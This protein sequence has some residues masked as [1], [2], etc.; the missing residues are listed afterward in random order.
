MLKQKIRIQLSAN[1][2]LD[3]HFVMLSQRLVKKMKIP[4]DRNLT[5]SFGAARSQIRVTANSRLDDMEM[6]TK[7]AQS[8][9]LHHNMILKLTYKPSSKTL[10]LGPILGVMVNRVYTKSAQRPFGAL[11]PFCQELTEACNAEG[12]Y[13]YF[14][15]PP[16]SRPNNQFMEGWSYSKGWRKTEV[17]IPNVVYNRLTTRLHENK[18]SVQHFMMDVKS[19][20]GS[21]VFNEKFLNKTEVF[22]ALK[23]ESSLKSVLP[24]SHPLRSFQRLKSMCSRHSTVFVKPILGS[25]GKGIIRICREADSSYTCYFAQ[26]NGTQKQK[27][28]NLNRVYSSISRKIRARRYQIQQGL[29]LISIGSRL[30]DFRSLVQRNHKGEWSV[31]SIVARIASQQHFV[32]NLARGGTI[33]SVRDALIK[34]NLSNSIVTKT[35]QKLR[36]VSIEIAQGI[37]KNIPSHFAELGVDLAVDTAGRVWLLEVNSKPSKNDKALSSSKIRPSVK[38]VVKY[39]Q[40]L[41]GL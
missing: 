34:S 12:V 9:R 38:Q 24:E 23:K 7:I 21:H 19:Q 18:Q 22:Q 17:P 11:T 29:K 32:S 5:L 3:T 28:K 26:L 36:Q 41:S 40:H 35:H 33:S 20:Y 8:L 16:L 30:V 25:L 14:F 37:E 27:Y 6:S 4:T 31:T 1:F 15:P 13:V 2:S 39:T 10:V